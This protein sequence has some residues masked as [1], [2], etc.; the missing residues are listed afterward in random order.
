[1]DHTEEENVSNTAHSETKDH[2]LD[3][4]DSQHT[5]AD[6]VEDLVAS[7]GSASKQAPT[8]VEEEDTSASGLA[9]DPVAALDLVEENGVAA[10]EV[11]PVDGDDQA[12][13][14]D[15]SIFDGAAVSQSTQELIPGQ[16]EVSNIQYST[17]SDDSPLE[18]SSSIVEED[19]TVGSELAQEHVSETV[20]SANFDGEAPKYAD[21]V[22]SAGNEDESGTS[23]D[24]SAAT[25]SSDVVALATSESSTDAPAAEQT[26]SALDSSPPLRDGSDPSGEEATSM[27]QS[28][29][30][31][32]ANEE[33]SGLRGTD[34]EQED[35]GVADTRDIA[36]DAPAP[37]SS[38]AENLDEKI[39][40]IEDTA[41]DGEDAGEN[42]DEDIDA[43]VD[44]EEETADRDLEDLGEDPE[45]E[46][47]GSFDEDAAIP[48]PNAPSWIVDPLHDS[49]ETWFLDEVLEQEQR[50]QLLDH[51]RELRELSDVVRRTKERED[52]LQELEQVLLD[53]TLQTGQLVEEVGDLSG[54]V[55][56]YK[57]QLRDAERKVEEAL[58]REAA[59][60][61]RLTRLQ[62]DMEAAESRSAALHESEVAK[63]SARVLS[64]EADVRDLERRAIREEEDRKAVE[65]KNLSL[66]KQLDEE[67]KRREG[68]VRRLNVL[69]NQLDNAAT[70]VEHPQPSVRVE[71]PRV[72]AGRR[73]PTRPGVPRIVETPP[74]GEQAVRQRSLPRNTEPPK[75]DVKPASSSQ[76]MAR[77]RVDPYDPTPALRDELDRTQNLHREEVAKVSDLTTQLEALM[78]EAEGLKERLVELQADHL[79]EMESL[80]NLH[81]TDL[82]AVLEVRDSFRESLTQ[83]LGRRHAAEIESMRQQHSEEVA[84]LRDELAKLQTELDAVNA[85]IVAES[86]EAAAKYADLENRSLQDRLRFEIAIR[87][88]EEESA[89]LRRGTVSS[90]ERVQYEMM[91][92]KAEAEASSLKAQL[93]LM[94]E[95]TRGI[96]NDSMSQGLSR[97]SHLGIGMDFP[98]SSILR[99]S[100]ADVVKLQSEIV[101]LSE[102]LEASKQQTASCIQE[103]DRYE[104]MVRAAEV[105]IMRLRAERTQSRGSIDEKPFTAQHD[106]PNGFPPSRPVATRPTEEDAQTLRSEIAI[107]AQ[108]LRAGEESNGDDGPHIEKSRTLEVGRMNGDV[109]TAPVQPGVVASTIA[110]KDEKISRLQLEL[111]SLATEKDNKISRLETQLGVFLAEADGRIA[112]MQSETN[113]LLV[114]RDVKLTELENEL[115]I[116]VAERE[117][118]EHSHQQNVHKLQGDITKLIKQI[119]DLEAATAR[120][121]AHLESRLQEDAEKY[122]ELQAYASNSR[123]QLETR[124]AHLEAELTRLSQFSDDSALAVHVETA[125][126]DSQL[127]ATSDVLG[128]VSSSVNSLFDKISGIGNREPYEGSPGVP[129]SGLRSLPV[130][131]PEQTAAAL[132]A[133]VQ[134]ALLDSQLEATSDMLATLTG[135]LQAVFADMAEM[136]TAPQH[137][138]SSNVNGNEEERP[139]SPQNDDDLF[140]DSPLMAPIHTSLAASQLDMTSQML[141]DVSTN[142][143]SLFE[144]IGALHAD[145]A[146]RPRSI[147]AEQTEPMLEIISDNTEVGQS[148]ERLRDFTNVQ[149]SQFGLRDDDQTTVP[150]E[151]VLLDSQLEATSEMLNDVT[152]NL[153]S[154]LANV[155]GLMAAEQLSPSPLNIQSELDNRSVP[156][157]VAM[158]S[159]PVETALLDSQLESTSEML[160]EFSKA[161]QTYVENVAVARQADAAIMAEAARN[162]VETQADELMLEQQDTMLSATIETALLDSQ[163]EATADMLSSVSSSVHEVVGRVSAERDHLAKDVSSLTAQISSLHL[164]LAT[165]SQTTRELEVSHE[166]VVA[167]LSIKHEQLLRER[168]ADHEAVIRTLRAQLSGSNQRIA[169]IEM[170]HSRSLDEHITDLSG[171]LDEVNTL[172]AQ[173]AV[174][175]ARSI[176]VETGH[177][178]DMNQQAAEHDAKVEAIEAELGRV[179]ARVVELELLL[180][181]QGT[182]Q[183]LE[184]TAVRAE[185]KNSHHRLEQ[186]QASIDQQ[187]EDHKRAIEDLNSIHA[188]NVAILE[189]QLAEA[190]THLSGSGETGNTGVDRDLGTNADDS[191]VLAANSRIVELEATLDQMAGSHDLKIESLE[192]KISELV[193]ALERLGEEHARLREERDAE[194]ASKVAS[195]DS[196]L[197]ATKDRVVE[198]E[199]ELRSFRADASVEQSNALNDLIPDNASKVIELQQQLRFT[200][201]SLAEVEEK[202]RQVLAEQDAA[203]QVTTAAVQAAEIGL[204]A[205]IGELEAHILE[206]DHQ[207]RNSMAEVA[208]LT[209]IEAELNVT[210][211]LLANLELEYGRA[212]E[213]A[214]AQLLQKETEHG[215]VLIQQKSEHE[216]ALTELQEKL[217]NAEQ[218]VIELG[219]VQKQLEQVLTRDSAL[220][221][222]LESAKEHLR[223]LEA[224]RVRS[225]DAMSDHDSAVKLIR[226]DLARAEGRVK[227]LE[228]E[229]RETREDHVRSMEAFDVELGA[230][231]QT[232]ADLQSQCM[233]SVKAAGEK[234]S[235]LTAMRSA[236]AESEEKARTLDSEIQQHLDV[237][238]SRLASL[239]EEL[240]SSK[241]REEDLRSQLVELQ[242]HDGTRDDAL[243]QLETHLTAA[244]SRVVDVEEQLLSISA[245]RETE[246]TRLNDSLT[247]LRE[248]HA[249]T[250]EAS[251]KAIADLRAMISIFKAEVK[252][253]EEQTHDELAQ[254]GELD[255]KLMNCQDTLAILGSSL[256]VPGGQ[257]LR[258]LSPAADSADMP[259]AYDMTTRGLE[260][261][262]QHEQVVSALNDQLASKIAELEQLRTDHGLEMEQ[263]EVRLTTIKNQRAADAKKVKTAITSLQNRIEELRSQLDETSKAADAKV[264]QAQVEFDSKLQELTS[265]RDRESQFA[266]ERIMNLQMQLQEEESKISQIQGQLKASQNELSKATARAV[267]LEYEIRDLERE[268]TRE[269]ETF[270]TIVAD[271]SQH[272]ENAVAREAELKNRTLELEQKV[273]AAESSAA[274]LRV[275]LDTVDGSQRDLKQQLENAASREQKVTH[276]TGEL[277]KEIK[278]AERVAEELR[279]QLEQSLLREQVASQTIQDLRSRLQSGTIDAPE[280]DDSTSYATTPSE[281]SALIAQ[282]RSQLS[283]AGAKEDQI[284]KSNRELE[285][286]LREAEESLAKIKRDSNVIRDDQRETSRD[287]IIGG[288]PTN[289]EELT[290]EVERLNAQLSNR[291]LS[292][293]EADTEIERLG[294][295]LSRLSA[296]YQEATSELEKLAS[297]QSDLL[298][299]VGSSQGVMEEGRS[300]REANQQSEQQLQVYIEKVSLLEND[301]L[302]KTNEHALRVVEYEQAASQQ[303]KELESVRQQLSVRENEVHAA[304]MEV[305]K[306]Q[307][308][309]DD[310]EATLRVQ[311]EST[312]AQAKSR[313]EKVSQLR[314]ELEVRQVNM[315]QLLQKYADLE[316]EYKEYVLEKREETSSFNNQLAALHEYIEERDSKIAELASQNEEGK[317]ELLEEKQAG[318]VRVQKLQSRIEAQDEEY[319]SLMTEVARDLDENQ[320]EKKILREKLEALENKLTTEGKDLQ[321]Q[322]TALDAQLLT[323][324]DLVQQIVPTLST[325]LGVSGVPAVLNVVPTQP[326]VETSREVPKASSSVE[327]H[328]LNNAIEKLKKD[329]EL[330]LITL[331]ESHQRELQRISHETAIQAADAELENIRKTEIPPPPY[332]TNPN[333]STAELLQQLELARLK[334]EEEQKAHTKKLSHMKTILEQT[335]HLFPENNQLRQTIAMQTRD[336]D[337]LEEQLKELED[338]RADLEETNQELLERVA[339]LQSMHGPD[340]EDDQE[341]HEARAAEYEEEIR[342]LRLEFQ[343]Q[344]DDYQKRLAKVQMMT[345]IAH[346]SVSLME[347]HLGKIEERL[348]VQ[349]QNHTYEIQEYADRL[350]LMEANYEVRID[351]LMAEHEAKL[352]AL[353][354]EITTLHEALAA[355]GEKNAERTQSLIDEVRSGTAVVHDYEYRLGLLEV[356]G[357]KLVN[358]IKKAHEETNGLGNEVANYDDDVR[359]LVEEA[360]KLGQAA[361][362][363]K[364]TT[365]TLRSENEKLRQQL[366]AVGSKSV[367]AA[368]SVE[369]TSDDPTASGGSPQTIYN[370][371]SDVEAL[372]LTSEKK[373][374]QAELEKA[375]A[376]ISELQQAQSAAA[377]EVSTL[378]TQLNSV[379]S[380]INAL[381]SEKDQLSSDLTLLRT[382]HNEEHDSLMAKVSTLEDQI[383]SLMSEKSAL[384][385]QLKEQGLKSALLQQQTPKLKQQVKDLKEEVAVQKARIAELQSR[386]GEA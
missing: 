3:A 381:R 294:E 169:E 41:N 54:Q 348:K 23:L 131:A 204:K 31:E 59:M 299:Q 132:L 334:L 287:L 281:S 327:I 161:L 333:A 266:A 76:K 207:Y 6:V 42:Q 280:S 206:Q 61:K 94:A 246:R 98:A 125:L 136:A 208:K 13:L 158:F 342:N 149:S 83:E 19:P 121:K 168:T 160:E 258:S 146:S 229:L 289:S 104:S 1:M 126:L 40:T 385:N 332:T 20:M 302:A 362:V 8:P 157:S 142:L 139:V 253:R 159:I 323:S 60:Q 214:N 156:E 134:A 291:D 200:T 118:L 111:A 307:E 382:E 77:R 185:L 95:R 103:R 341:L 129:R 144:H 127:R 93:A 101:S 320:K 117:G 172:K 162:L 220:E 304:K 361:E 165:A 188:E 67:R 250:E 271:L 322:V 140:D 147:Q 293:K 7:A 24:P 150:V 78:V 221:A 48:A 319:Q 130:A 237:H 353:E 90:Q 5:L 141:A 14:Q 153:E 379:S 312:N 110:E 268:N 151:T 39:D 377:A 122:R 282:L 196:E 336:L 259:P 9:E 21:F 210:K 260:V 193:L 279:E 370:E 345:N 34:G 372:K 383:S 86:R 182:E 63:H 273:K 309:V 205:R 133:P 384:E 245:E 243:S 227:E 50:G 242:R 62:E 170:D 91:V 300:L 367:F 277:E 47:I 295:E 69:G 190:R 351:S 338:T 44:G 175:Q 270:K 27:D 74:A 32:D 187:K 70:K 236:L 107:L 89:N 105:E 244:R 163:L 15:N 109:G 46:S 181:R 313:D 298:S 257:N 201:S 347:Q 192:A 318:T 310:L 84:H 66:T 263:A 328:R 230:S 4:M 58:E 224:D 113:A 358:G 265:E 135:T 364:K 326:Q 311:M 278:V 375:Q 72:V 344:E 22:E 303:K 359:T 330:E 355:E 189:N 115:N 26:E 71:H 123:L 363:W 301:I 57:M 369:V 267:G 191:A 339:Q 308:Q 194:H 45:V 28:E 354:L 73:L 222:E 249:E 211:Q 80:Q 346:T 11:T 10:P 241:I 75:A 292:I 171:D 223:Q 216:A 38:V 285:M 85:R 116:L 231:K 380:T 315:N 238:T 17:P 96:T 337:D 199:E 52:R 33:T 213:E 256:N 215:T 186:L 233:D 102:R 36:D 288:T 51:L 251:A 120:E 119:E 324:S 248:E 145:L 356:E 269:K 325:L 349:E 209:E 167:K 217:A 88:A 108:R 183:A 219:L 275:Q 68:L 274:Q 29:D 106:A 12:S 283:L 16:D 92:Q 255:Q 49:P 286:K 376:Q 235:A 64:L 2:L 138:H 305:M 296:L 316:E 329:H 30:L 137:S 202:L 25:M 164:Q 368:A 53:K 176:Q 179:Q 352:E 239:E 82:E 148:V 371:P 154:L 331:K 100:D 178:R 56:S 152:T 99:Q 184:L 254:I 212:T 340:H 180:D 335:N 174:A 232:I 143:H 357:V 18:T 55:A 97:D 261:S 218:S 297:R 197:A 240:S 365:E 343:E 360:E 128:E 374:L 276:I 43:A 386:V 317:R 228:S 306:L 203:H 262:V 366:Q 252:Q 35:G 177:R 114:Q 81:K 284:S 112:Q 124:I 225:L 264:A 290:R 373:E 314:E 166:E 378:S 65:E 247:A 272:L 234:D 195:F 155:R 79:R 173:L 226:S 87:K 350:Q 198:L 37:E 321:E